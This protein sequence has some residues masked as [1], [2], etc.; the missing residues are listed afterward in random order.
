MPECKNCH[1]EISKFDSDVCPFCGTPHP[2][3]DNYKTKDMTSF[4]DPITGNYKLYRSKSRKAAFALCLSLGW[5]GAHFFYL[6]FLKKGLISIVVSLLIIA[7]VGLPLFFF[8]PL[9]SFWSFV[10]AFGLCWII[11]LPLAIKYL[12]SDSYKD[13]N[14]E[15][16]R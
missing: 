9:L 10:I 15:F 12:F 2:I 14:G 13:A 5:A 11:Y 8:L 1:R 16:L 3:D 7:G 6:G 4:V